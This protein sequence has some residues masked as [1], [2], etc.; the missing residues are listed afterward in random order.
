MSYAEGIA[1][2]MPA[3]LVPAQKLPPR[4]D[5][6]QAQVMLSSFPPLGQVTKASAADEEFSFVVCLQVH[7][8][9]ADRPWQVALSCTALGRAD[10]HD[11]I[12]IS[13]APENTPVSL[14]APD[15]V[16]API[17]FT[18]SSIA[19]VAASFT[20]KFRESPHLPWREAREDL[21]MQDGIILPM[22]S[23]NLP[24]NLRRDIL[25]DI[26]LDVVV[27]PAMSQTPAT[28]LWVIEAP[29]SGLGA[30]GSDQSVF[31]DV[32]LGLPWN[33][34]IL[35]WFALVRIWSPWLAPRHGKTQFAVQEDVVVSAFL[36]HHGRHLVLLPI[37][38]AAHVTSVLRSSADGRVVLHAQ[39]DRIDDAT[40][41]VVAAVGESFENTLAACMYHA[42]DIVQAHTAQQYSKS[43]LVDTQAP[44]GDVRSDWMEDWYD[45]LGFCTWNALGQHLTEDVILQ[46]L[47]TLAEKNIQIRNLII[48]DGWQDNYP[49]EDGQFQSGL[50]AFEASPIKFP[51]GLKALV[52][53]IRSKYS[54]IQHVSVWHALLGYWGGVAPGGEISRSYKTVEVLR[55]EAKRRNFPMGGKMTV[56]AKEDVDR[57]YD[58]FYSFLASCGVDGV[59]TDAQFVLD[60]WVG[61]VARRELTDAYLDAWTSASLRRFGNRTISCMSQVPHFIFHSQMPRHRPAISVRNSDDFFPEIPASHPWH[62]WAN[63]HNSLFTQY[64][65]VVPD[66]DMFQTSHSY[67]SYHAA[68]RAISGGPIY[69]T[70][71]PGQ[72]DMELLAQLTGVTPRGKTV[73][74][75]PSVFS[76]SIDAYVGYNDDSLLKVGSYHGDART[77]TPIMGVFNVAA[78]P[79]TD[80]I[81]LYRF[82][83]V[84]SQNAYV[85]RAHTTGRVTGPMRTTSPP[86][87][88][89]VSL[90]ERGYEILTAF[91]LSTFVSPGG[92]Q[93][94]M[95][96]LGLLGKMAG[97]AALV[98]SDIKLENGRAILDIRVK[99]LGTIGVYFSRLPKIDIGDDTIAMIQGA[100]IPQETVAVSEQDDH[101]LAV[102]VATAWTKMGLDSGWSNEVQLMLYISIGK[103]DSST[104]T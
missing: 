48:D 62:V 38:D 29:I 37:S 22:A 68:A 57:F 16:I 46:A 3:A 43:D 34:A 13:A 11:V 15:T 70:D 88:L 100:V 39:C 44:A 69:I 12:L 51:R 35:R 92:V 93:L 18:T 52:S 59:K 84:R 78:R 54:H 55:K 95:A 31:S 42:R 9:L 99:A 7:S 104:A 10:W 60:T 56:V 67:S 66:W 73:V 24:D 79:M 25:Q 53:A 30:S 47:G 40:V 49:S 23:S 74:F 17:Y 63:A 65:N 14:S 103:L 26:G 36:D 102:D 8:A 86:S 96:S 83:G 85:V 97:A 50:N 6:A 2:G 71:V 80:I 75:R 33:G 94:H 41:K 58:D 76:K 4:A 61:S 32:D 81:P 21:L 72:H 28:N 77:G 91:S 19:H 89:S 5:S 27:K 90:E 64:L 20:F 98:S 87:M 82:A 1:T 101:V 45:G